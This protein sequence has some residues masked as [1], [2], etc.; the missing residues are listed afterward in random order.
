MSLLVKRLK[1]RKIQ[2][3]DKGSSGQYKFGEKVI[4]KWVD[5]NKQFQDAKQYQQ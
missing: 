1:R 2:K 5:I 3:S 4:A